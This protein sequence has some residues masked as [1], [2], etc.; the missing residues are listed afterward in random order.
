MALTDA[1]KYDGRTRAAKRARAQMRLRLA[2]ASDEE[3]EELAKLEVAIIPED[4]L[5][6]VR[7]RLRNLK[8]LRARIRKEGINRSELQRR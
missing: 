7:E 8:E 4:I 6:G 2:T 1:L 3:L 5:K